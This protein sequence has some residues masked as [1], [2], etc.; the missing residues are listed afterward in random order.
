MKMVT[1]INLLRLVLV[2]AILYQEQ[3]KGN[4]H[5]DHSCNH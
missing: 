4:G 3:H 5:D 1:R 2:F